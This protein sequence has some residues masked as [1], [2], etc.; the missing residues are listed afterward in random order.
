MRK[1]ALLSFVLLL[2]S[3]ILALLVDLFTLKYRSGHSVSGNGNPGVLFVIFGFVCLI[4]LIIT[5]SQ[6]TKTYYQ[7]HPDQ[8]SNKILSCIFIVLFALMAAG[9]ILKINVLRETLNGFTNHET[10][11]VYRFGWINQYT[12]HLFYNIYVIGMGIT[13]SFF[14][15]RLLLSRG[16]RF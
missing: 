10:S 2:T 1:R 12:N 8:R 5:T 6:L 11:I 13:I 15:G 16:Y 4:T 7:N 3:I 9:E 14:L